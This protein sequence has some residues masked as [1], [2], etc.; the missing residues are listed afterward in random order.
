MEPSLIHRKAKG[1]RWEGVELL[2]Y[3]EDDR[4]LFKSVTRQILFS[5][6]AQQSELRYFEVAAGGFSTLQRHDHTHNVLILRG[7]G[8][9]LVGPEVRRLPTTAPIPP[10][11]LS[12]PPRPPRRP[13]PGSPPRGP[14]PSASYP[15]PPPAATSPSFRAP[16]TSPRSSVTPRSRRSCAGAVHNNQLGARRHHLYTAPPPPNHEMV[17]RRW[18]SGPGT[19]THPRVGG[20]E[21]R[22]AKAVFIAL[23][24]LTGPAQAAP[25]RLVDL[26]STESVLRWINSY[27]TK[28]DPAGVPAAVQALSRFGALRDPE[29]AGAY[30][31]FIAGVIGTN[32]DKAEA[33]IAKML[34]L[35]PGDQW[36]I[37]RAIAY[38]G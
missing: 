8:H 35:P 15:W 20:G 34:P 9:C 37:V 30:V 23:L 28:P 1:Y 12:S 6:P 18:L 4:A 32:P 27:R 22:R 10:P 16:R 2:P 21:M 29:Q 24:L 14:S 26:T 36:I 17:A 7:S 33:L 13:G 19:S 3:K 25:S 38:S 11:P 5:D 31:G